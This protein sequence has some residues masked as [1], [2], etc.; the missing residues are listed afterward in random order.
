[1]LPK[2]I[3]QKRVALRMARIP[4]IPGPLLEIT[5]SDRG[6]WAAAEREPFGPFLF[7]V[8]DFLSAAGNKANPRKVLKGS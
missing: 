1:M 5:S 2:Y 7:F 6:V 3:G 8:N 4:R